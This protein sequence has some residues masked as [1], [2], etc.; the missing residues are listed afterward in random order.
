MPLS[1]RKVIT[2]ILEECDKLPERCTDYRDAVRDT[3]TDIFQY[4]R[5]HLTAATNIQQ[6]VDQACDSAAELLVRASRRAA[7]E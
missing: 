2:I 7:K 1:D 4:E 6:K 3:I 5:K